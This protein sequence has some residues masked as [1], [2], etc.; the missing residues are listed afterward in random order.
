M[1]ASVYFK[2]FIEEVDTILKNLESV[3]NRL[4]KKNWPQD[5]KISSIA[6]DIMQDLLSIGQAIPIL[7]PLV[8]SEVK[9]CVSLAQIVAAYTAALG[10]YAAS[11]I[12]KD[13]GMQLRKE[14]ALQIGARGIDSLLYSGIGYI[15][16]GIIPL[17]NELDRS[18]FVSLQ[19]N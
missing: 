19:R 10:F 18:H 5:A 11:E 15:S 8:I 6:V 2:N 9:A 14:A 4:V 3:E 12:M 7:G 1:N 16:F 13:Q 17:I